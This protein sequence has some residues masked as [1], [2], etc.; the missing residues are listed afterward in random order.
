[1]HDRVT[2]QTVTEKTRKPLSTKA[3]TKLMIIFEGGQFP[4]LLFC[5]GNIY[6][7][8]T[9]FEIDHLVSNQS[10]SREFMF[11]FCISCIQMLR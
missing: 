4:M 8:F 5:A 7:Y 11:T 9:E 10:W 3:I 6:Y 1:M 2:I